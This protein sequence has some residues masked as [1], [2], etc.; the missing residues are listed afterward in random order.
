VKRGLLGSEPI[1]RGEQKEMGIEYDQRTN[2]LH[3]QK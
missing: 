3:I 2:Y 1:E